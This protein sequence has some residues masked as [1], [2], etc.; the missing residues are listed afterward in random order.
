MYAKNKFE[1]DGHLSSDVYCVTIK[2][3]EFN[4]F[5]IH[6][7]AVDAE[8]VLKKAREIAD[9]LSMPEHPEYFLSGESVAIYEYKISEIKLVT[10]D[11]F[12][13]KLPSRQE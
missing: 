11:V 8:E 1:E 12:I 13:G 10:Q 5:N 9:I 6:I 3:S 4:T 2:F 7:I